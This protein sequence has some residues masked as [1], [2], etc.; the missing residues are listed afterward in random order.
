MEIGYKDMRKFLQI[1]KE[2][3]TD[4]GYPLGIVWAN[5]KEAYNQ[6]QLS[7]DDIRFMLKLKMQFADFPQKD[8][9]IWL[10]RA[11]EVEEYYKA[12]GTLSMPNSTLFHDGVSMFQWKHH[13]KKS[14]KQGEL[15][16]YQRERLERMGIQWIKPKQVTG[17]NEGY[18]YAK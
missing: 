1:P 16:M 14:Y 6:N 4:G 18:S 7:E 2:Y 8:L 10:D 9:E 11:D 3:I 13:Q 12:H 15:S 17:W 5:L